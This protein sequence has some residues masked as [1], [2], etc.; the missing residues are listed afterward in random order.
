[1]STSARRKPEGHGGDED[2]RGLRDEPTD[3]LA[4]AAALGALQAAAAA[5]ADLYSGLARFGADES[6]IAELLLPSARC[7][8][9]SVLGYSRSSR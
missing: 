8:A 7:R 3:G 2:I 9:S 6:N 5:A 1:M 4:R